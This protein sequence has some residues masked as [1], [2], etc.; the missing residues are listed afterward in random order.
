MDSNNNSIDNYNDSSLNDRKRVFSNLFWRMGERYSVQI[1]QFIVQIVLARILNPEIFGTVSLILIFVNLLQVFVDSG[2]GNA[3]IQKKEVDDIDYSSVFFFNIFFCIILYLVV[4]LFAP[5]ISNLFKKDITLVIRVL[6]IVILIS[7]VKNVQQAYVSRHLL[8]KKFFVATSIGTVI[9]AVV[10][11]LMAIKGYGV[12]AIVAQTL[13]NNAIDTMILWLIVRWRPKLLFSFKRLSVLLKFGWKLLVSALINVSYEEIR[14]LIIGLKYTDTDLAFYNRG[15]QFPKFIV[16]SINS[17]IDSVLFPSLSKRQNNIEE[18]K[19]VV[20]RA[21]KTSFYI[22]SPMMVGLAVCANSVVRL[23]LTEKWIDCV[24]FLQIMCISYVFYPIH[25]ANLNSIQALGHSGYFLTLEIIKKTLGVTLL[26]ISMW[27][28][29]FWIAVSMMTT[30]IISVFINSY[31]NR[32]LLNYNYLQQ[33]VDILPTLAISIIMGGLV[34]S[35]SFIPLHYLVVLTIQ[36]LSGITIY[37]IL[38]VVFKN[39][40][41]IYLKN[42]LKSFII[43]RKERKK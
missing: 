8:F 43:F 28:G 38:S 35:L 39:E 3:L 33:I 7:G 21:I 19:K 17:S 26:V 1:V 25:T 40:S 10:S 34:Y 4:F 23:V 6:S 5:L 15:E 20:R 24:P 11:I 2:L 41:Y 16:T 27:F 14:Q 29:P 36:V 22:I 18:V 32:K 31:P 12:W 13:I 42:T 37:F 9:S 30:S